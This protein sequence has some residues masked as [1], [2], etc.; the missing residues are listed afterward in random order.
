MI[1]GN[2]TIKIGGQYQDA[3][4]QE[5]SRPGAAELYFGYHGTY[6]D[7]SA[8]RHGKRNR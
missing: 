4:H 3:L 8:G 1:K 7:M 6:G 2:H 5:P